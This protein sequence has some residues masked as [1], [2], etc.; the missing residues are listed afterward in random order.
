VR[1]FDFDDAN[2]YRGKLRETAE[3]GERAFGGE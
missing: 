3:D 1:R 2:K